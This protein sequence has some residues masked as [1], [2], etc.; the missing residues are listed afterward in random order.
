MLKWKKLAA[1]LLAGALTFT[2]T[3]CESLPSE[4]KTSDLLPIGESPVAM[5]TVTQDSKDGYLTCTFYI[6]E[7]WTALG[8]DNFLVGAFPENLSGH[9]VPQDAFIMSYSVGITNYYLYGAPT[10]SQEQQKAYQSLL[11]G[12]PQ[13]YRAWREER[14]AQSNEAWKDFVDYEVQM[15]DFQCSYYQGRYGTVVQ[16]EETTT[17]GTTSV[18]EVDWFRT[19]IPEYKVAGLYNDQLE[20]SSGGI[21]RYVMDSLQVEEHFTVD[22]GMIHKEGE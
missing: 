12:D 22:D 11:A 17:D 21:A 4:E 7:D 6:P 5:K 10:P 18:T 13:P 9:E 2:F 15:T 14:I 16:V 19:D 3:A 1:L 8:G 20:L